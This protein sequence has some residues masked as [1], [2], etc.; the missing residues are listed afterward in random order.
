MED[1]TMKH[2]TILI[3]ALFF[4]YPVIAQQ[5]TLY[6]G[7]IKS[8]WYAAPVA[9]V[10]QINSVT[11]YLI[12][13]EGGWILNHR[14]VLGAKGYILTNPF[15]IHDLQNITVGFGGGGALFKYIIASDKLAHFSI[16]SLIGAGGVYNDIKDSANHDPIDYTGDACFIL[17][18]G[19]NAVLN[20]SENFRIGLGFTYRY[21]SG[22]EYDPGAPY[23]NAAGNGHDAISNSDLSGF[24][25][26]LIFKYGNF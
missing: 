23:Q 12:G 18:P 26:Q 7:K 11:G 25:V 5:E 9:K 10:G 14:F 19:I 22:I 24:S 8:G 2:I 17:E 13:V 21:V 15:D 1:Q 4:A 6:N 16:E 20:V 3:L